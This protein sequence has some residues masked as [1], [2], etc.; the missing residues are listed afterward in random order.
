M[1]SNNGSNLEDVKCVLCYAVM[2]LVQDEPMGRL[3][4]CPQG[5]SREKHWGKLGNRADGVPSNA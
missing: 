1:T 3:Y 5:H 4:V 2:T